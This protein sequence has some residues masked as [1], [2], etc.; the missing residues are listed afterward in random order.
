M[1]VRADPDPDGGLSLAV[2][3]PHAGPFALQPLS[4]PPGY[5]LRAA[6]VFEV[7]E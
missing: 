1:T 3:A 2:T 7:E 6:L 4:L 5:S